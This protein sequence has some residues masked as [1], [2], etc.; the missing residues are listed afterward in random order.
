MTI[1]RRFDVI[2]RILQLTSI[3]SAVFA[4]TGETAREAMK[5]GTENHQFFPCVGG[6]GHASSVAFGYALQSKRPTLCLDGDGALLMHLG[7]LTSI[8]SWIGI[9]FTH[10]LFDNGCHLSV[11]GNK[12]SGMHLNYLDLARSLGYQYVTKLEHLD[13]LKDDIGLGSINSPKTHFVYVSVVASREKNL[14]RPTNLSS[15]I[16]KFRETW[17]T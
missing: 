17:T 4:T 8:T 1:F 9:N 7:A 11:G 6:M 15:F 2:T 12:T 13:Q 14:P 5:A 10:F 16:E 3:E